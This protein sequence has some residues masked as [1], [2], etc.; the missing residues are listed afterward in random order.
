M[1]CGSRA[2]CP[3][4]T[5]WPISTTAAAKPS[6]SA[7]ARRRNP[8]RCSRRSAGR[9]IQ[10][11][12]HVGAFLAEKLHA[13]GAKLVITDV[14]QAA[15]D[16]VVAKTGAKVVAPEAIFD[17][18]VQVFAPCA[19]GGA[20]TPATLER[21]KG[22]VVA[23]GA[24]NQ[25]ATPEA[26]EALFA[27]GM[28]YAPDYVINGGGIINVAG[29]IRALEAGATFDPAW[30]EGKLSRLMETLDEVFQRS[31]DEKRP[32][33]EIAGEIARARIEAARR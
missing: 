2:P 16:E 26:G 18:E 30:V 28:I 32:T 22:R 13:A 29:E 25:L 3:T 23:G 10:G 11:V 7:T 19:L 21:L 8:R 15:L 20:I 14:N 9:W 5:R 4:R 27:K 17:A 33:H 12:G 1:R 24:N 31:I 6:S